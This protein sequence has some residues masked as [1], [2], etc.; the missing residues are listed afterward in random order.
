MGRKK[1]RR[2]SKEELEDL[3]YNEKLS[4]KE[5][6]ENYNVSRSTALKWIK[7]D[8]FDLRSRSEA[9]RLRW[10]SIK[11]NRPTKEE[12]ER[13]YCD[14]NLLQKEIASKYGVCKQVV[15]DWFKEDGIEARTR[16]EA[17]RLRLGL[18]L[19]LSGKPTKEELE[20]LYCDENLLQK[21]I[22][23][24]RGVSESTVRKWLKED[25]IEMRSHSDSMRIVHGKN[26]PPEV[27]LRRLH[28]K[29]KLPLK[30]IARIFEVAPSTMRGWF[31]ECNIKTRSII[32]NN[33][34]F[35]EFLRS[36][37]TALKLSAVAASLNEQGYEIEKVVDD[38][39]EGKFKN[40]TDL[41]RLITENK[42]EIYVLVREGI[43]NLGPYMG[44]FSV[45]SREIIP[46]LLGE[47]LSNIPES[48]I[49]FSLEDRL[50]KILRSQYSPQFNEDPDST[51][52]D[53]TSRIQDS[54]GKVRGLYER[55]YEHYDQTMRLQE[56][57]GNA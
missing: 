24:L 50:L 17:N 21:E 26:R 36:D 40:Q 30:R 41:H 4:V 27:E 9:N 56:E 48:R 57:I 29:E 1:I 18:D 22:A 34:Q 47:A 46:V 32:N 13:L 6:G 53:I 25:G 33:L 7:D 51:M 28:I 39:Y 31:A 43:T 19:Q 55:L 15:I 52:R 14:E 11:S 38:I 3:Y 42:D 2:P 44:E 16:S 37:Q 45:G 20:R 8:G 54:E 5:I 12:L 49:E 23:D 35:M 10:Q